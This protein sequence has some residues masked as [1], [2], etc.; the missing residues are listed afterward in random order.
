M[1]AFRILNLHASTFAV[2]LLGGTRRQPIGPVRIGFFYYFTLDVHAN[3]AYVKSLRKITTLQL[4]D[5]KFRFWWR[6]QMKGEKKRKINRGEAIKIGSK[7][8]KEKK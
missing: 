4:H 1:V 6:K 7:E 2:F 8:G 5:S 3:D